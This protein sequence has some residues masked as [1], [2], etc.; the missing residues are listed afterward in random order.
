ML[1]LACCVHKLTSIHVD[2]FGGELYRNGGPATHL[3]PVR[4]QRSA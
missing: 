4:Q 3:N 1:L 2:L